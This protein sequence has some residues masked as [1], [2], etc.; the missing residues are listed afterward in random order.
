MLHMHRKNLK[1]C[2]LK[3]LQ[4]FLSSWIICDFFLFVRFLPSFLP[5]F[6]FFFLRFLFFFST[7]EHGMTYI[8]V[9]VKVYIKVYITFM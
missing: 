8:K 5:S 3:K 9:Y 4:L 7:N 2:I 6:P 1:E